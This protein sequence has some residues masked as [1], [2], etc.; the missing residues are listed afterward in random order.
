VNLLFK[1]KSCTSS[2]VLA[3][4]V[5]LLTTSLSSFADTYELFALH[6]DQDYF[7]YG[8]DDSGTVVITN[9]PDCETHNCF[10]TYSNG[11][12]Y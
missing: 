4:A 11:A 10:F 7:F 3:I 1:F 5:L 12:L 8:M 6:S 9:A 2:F